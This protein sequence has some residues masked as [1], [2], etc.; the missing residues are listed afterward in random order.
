MFILCLLKEP[1]IRHANWVILVCN[2]KEEN[3][4]I[5]A[6]GHE[7]QQ[8]SETSSFLFAHQQNTYRDWWSEKNTHDIMHHLT[9][10][11]H[12]CKLSLYEEFR[13]SSDDFRSV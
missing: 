13:K 4:S 9:S 8:Q 6:Q 10:I 7:Q 11:A 5:D 1:E 12:T 3:K 2:F